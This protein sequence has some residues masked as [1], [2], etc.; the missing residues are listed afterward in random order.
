MLDV[1]AARVLRGATA[2]SFSGNA[3]ENLA[4]APFEEIVVTD[5]IPLRPGPRQHPRVVLSPACSLRLDQADL[6]G[7]FGSREFSGGQPAVLARPP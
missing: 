2:G 4:A 3:Y 7:R 5:T 1:G 6:H